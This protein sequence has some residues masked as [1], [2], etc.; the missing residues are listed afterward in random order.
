MQ[1]AGTWLTRTAVTWINDCCLWRETE[2]RCRVVVLTVLVNVANLDL[3]TIIVLVVEL[4]S[5]LVD[6]LLRNARGKIA[7]KDLDHTLG[8]GT[9]AVSGA[10]RGSAP[11][12]PSCDTASNSSGDSG[13]SRAHLE[14]ASGSGNSDE[15][16]GSGNHFCGVGVCEKAGC[17]LVVME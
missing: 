2:I 16:G 3:D 4:T 15:S 6:G 12:G 5:A 10:D 11:D 13:G 7:G 14:Y 8:L 17:C 9:R 1:A